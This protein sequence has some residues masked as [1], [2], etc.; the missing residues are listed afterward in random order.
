MG[1]LTLRKTFWAGVLA[2]AG[3]LAIG[4]SLPA[5]AHDYCCSSGSGSSFYVTDDTCAQA[6]SISGQV[7]NSSCSGGAFTDWTGTP[8]EC[9]G[10]EHTAN[11]CDC[12]CAEYD[13]DTLECIL[14]DCTLYKFWDCDTIVYYTLGACGDG[15]VDAGEQCDPPGSTIPCLS[16]GPGFQ[17]CQS[18]CT[19]GS[20]TIG[21]SCGNGVVESGEQC[22]PPGSFCPNGQTC[23]ASCTCPS[24][25]D[26]PCYFSMSDAK[27]VVQVWEDINGD[28]YIQAAWDAKRWESPWISNTNMEVILADVLSGYTGGTLY[29]HF[30]S[31]FDYHGDKT[32][33]AA[34]VNMDFNS[35]PG[36]IPVSNQLRPVLK[37]CEG[38]CNPFDGDDEC[39]FAGPSDLTGNGQRAYSVT[40]SDGDVRVVEEGCSY[41]CN[42]G[43]ADPSCGAETSDKE[44]N[45]D[46]QIRD[47]DTVQFGFG[48]WRALNA[49]RLVQTPD[50]VAFSVRAILGAHCGA[51]DHSK[52]TK[53]L[54]FKSVCYPSCLTKCGQLDG[55]GGTCA[56]TD[57]KWTYTAWSPNCVTGCPA[58]GQTATR[59]ATNPCSPC[60]YASCGTVPAKE[61]LT[62]ACS[63]C[64]RVTGG[65]PL[66]VPFGQNF[67]ST[68]SLLPDRVFKNS[69]EV[70]NASTLPLNFT[71]QDGDSGRG[72]PD[73]DCLGWGSRTDRYKI[74]ILNFSDSV[75][76]QNGTISNT[77]HN[78]NG[79]SCTDP[80]NFQQGLALGKTYRWYV[81]AENT[82]CTSGAPDQSLDSSNKYVC[83]PDCRPKLCGQNDNCGASQT[84]ADASSNFINSGEDDCYWDDNNNP[85]KP[86][87]LCVSTTADDTS[88]VTAS[89]NWRDPGLV[90]SDKKKLYFIWQTNDVKA[91]QAEDGFKLQILDMGDCRNILDTA[92]DPD[93][94]CNCCDPDHSYYA[95]GTPDGGA[96]TNTCD[97]Y[98]TEPLDW[99]RAPSFASLNNVNPTET[100]YSAA[101]SPTAGYCIWPKTGSFSATRHHLY[102]FRVASHNAT[103]EDIDKSTNVGL[104]KGKMDTLDPDGCPNADLCGGACT[105]TCTP[106]SSFGN[107]TACRAQ[108]GCSWVGLPTIGVCLGSCTACS[109][110]DLGGCTF[111]QGCSIQS[112]GDGNRDWSEWTQGYAIAL[113]KVPTATLIGPTCVTRS[114]GGFQD[115]WSGSVCGNPEN[116]YSSGEGTSFACGISDAMPKD[117]P[118]GQTPCAADNWIQPWDPPS[119]YCSDIWNYNCMCADMVS[120]NNPVLFKAQFTDGDGYD[121]LHK[122]KISFTAP[123]NSNC[124]DAFRQ[125]TGFLQRATTESKCNSDIN[126]DS[127]PCEEVSFDTSGTGGA[128]K[129]V[130]GKIEKVV[131]AGNNDL[132]GY[133]KVRFDE[134]GAYETNGGTVKICLDVD[135]FHTADD[136]SPWVGGNPATD[137]WNWKVDMKAPTIDQSVIGGMQVTNLLYMDTDSIAGYCDPYPD[138]D[139]PLDFPACAD[140]SAYDVWAFEV[141]VPISDYDFE[142]DGDFSRGMES[143]LAQDED[144]FKLAVDSDP[145]DGVVTFD[146]RRLPTIENGRE[147][148][149]YSPLF[150]YYND[151]DG[152]NTW[153]WVRMSSNPT[154]P[155][156][157]T[158]APNPFGGQGRFVA[159]LYIPAEAYLNAAGQPEKLAIKVNGNPVEMYLQ[160]ADQ[161][162]I[163]VRDGGGNTFDSGNLM[164]LYSGWYQAINGDI[165]SKG[166]IDVPI[167]DWVS[168]VDYDRYFL[169]SDKEPPPTSSQPDI[170]GGV[171]LSGPGSL[172]Y[173]NGKTSERPL[174]G[175]NYQW[176]EE[177]YSSSR[178]I[179]WN[180][181]LGFNW[182]DL[183]DYCAEGSALSDGVGVAWSLTA[184]AC[185]RLGASGGAE[186]LV[187]GTYQLNRDGVAVVYSP[188]DVVIGNSSKGVGE[189]NGLISTG[190]LSR[191]VILAVDGDVTIGWDVVSQLDAFIVATG[192]IRFEMGKSI[193]PLPINGAL[194]AQNG[195]EVDRYV[196][197]VY[198]PVL[199]LRHNPLYSSAEEGCPPFFCRSQHSWEE[200][201]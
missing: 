107:R 118:W 108:A 199:Q 157:Y 145:I 45:E 68:S 132:Y 5:A 26:E 41:G 88:C 34:T 176:A 38:F 25:P 83:R 86:V 75:W 32:Y 65:N 186:A 14:W 23:T 148:A 67:G 49:A 195:I 109:S 111:Q 16:G 74:W 141:T 47:D 110:I 100:T 58:C 113:N 20:C 178:L 57:N 182:A 119:L 167:S 72:C 99:T 87:G 135:D 155:F 3:L 175:A 200:L 35:T 166:G 36:E 187:E 15:D 2:V 193:D 137:P 138:P 37:D 151:Y 129:L 174:D 11:S 66:G 169:A 85:Q 50:K 13:P 163:Q 9:L 114:S 134:G 92:P 117:W 125:G 27:F 21:A 10:C 4:R 143:N 116:R 196:F 201:E 53:Y 71:W 133:F 136:E 144:S 77:F 124:D 55:C 46:F 192:Q 173:T 103:C 6:T 180:S 122:L 94:S 160:K 152:D 39:G 188:Q 89:D 130:D 183:V 69:I 172:I 128:W 70:L 95:D 90:D 165:Y 115:C 198:Q 44:L 105:G 29:L 7:Q 64:D 30:E 96:C 40:D 82:D 164:S 126:G 61:T 191:G 150:Y 168:D 181:A 106:C 158:V 159:K 56:N 33:N 22:D 120:Q 146:E 79:D 48:S 177:N 179:T 142:N 149:E 123:G 76:V 98:W 190:G 194:I 19:W 84:I 12:D 170:A 80:G 54:T 63:N 104:T 189:N 17:T 60:P 102:A 51:T 154:D 197:D 91:Q 52:E 131:G 140:T 59:T 78:C 184:G 43:G 73:G 121:D 112:G 156:H 185:F 62:Y 18:D 147:E 161:I 1:Q 31:A 162:R 24:I 127:L 93:V 139:K 8:A 81:R 28:R 97:D 42:F 153:E 101:C 171:V